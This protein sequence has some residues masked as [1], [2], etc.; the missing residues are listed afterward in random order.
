M[1]KYGSFNSASEKFVKQSPNVKAKNRFLH[2]EEIKDGP[3]DL[4]IEEIPP[5]GLLIT[6][7]ETDKPRKGFQEYVSTVRETIAEPSTLS[8][9]HIDE[10]VVYDVAAVLARS[11]SEGYQNDIPAT[12]VEE[13][14]A[15]KV[16]L[17][18]FL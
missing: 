7:K 3:Q 16:K 11:D 17:W 14:A 5:A 10:W 1:T 8:T 2:T 4:K 13:V 6:E 18:S 12:E 9:I 15:S